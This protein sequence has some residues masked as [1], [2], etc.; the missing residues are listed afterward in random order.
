[1]DIW[2]ECDLRGEK[3]NDNVL[4]RIKKKL[5]FDP[6]NKEEMNAYLDNYYNLK[7]NALSDEKLVSED[8]PSVWSRLSLEE[9]TWLYDNNLIAF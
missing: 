7:D 4:E 1:M 8:K 6:T 5:G 2:K 3:M 9:L